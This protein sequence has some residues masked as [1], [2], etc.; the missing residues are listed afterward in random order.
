PDGARTTCGPRPA[1]SRG[2]TPRPKHPKIG[3]LIAPNPLPVRAA[4]CAKNATGSHPG[5]NREVASM[6]K[7]ATI[8]AVMAL[9][10]LSAGFACDKDKNANTQAAGTDQSA[11][12]REVALTGY[13]TDSSC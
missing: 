6:K 7:F 8:F 12:A 1:R 4:N 13:L 2:L 9:V 11:G 3:G 5:E 10:A